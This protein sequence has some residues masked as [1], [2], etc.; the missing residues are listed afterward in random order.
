MPR[1][2]PRPP[3]NEVPPVTNL[4]ASGGFQ[5]TLEVNRDANGAI[6]GGKISAIGFVNFPGAATITGFHIH[7]GSS[8]TT[9]GI[10]FD[11]GIT[12]NNAVQVPM[13]VGLLTRDLNSDDAAATVARLTQLLTNPTNF[14]LNLHTTTHPNGALRA[15]LTKW[16]ESRANTVPM[17]ASQEVP[18]VTGVNAT[19]RAAILVNPTRN[20]TGQVN[21]GSITFNVAYEGFPP[22]TPIIGL[23]IHE[24]AAGTT[25]PIRFDTGLT[26]ANPHVSP[27]G[28]CFISITVPVTSADGIAALRRLIDNPTNFYVNLHT[29]TNPGGALRAQLTGLSNGAPAIALA[30]TY[31]LPTGS[32]NATISL[33]ATG[34]DLTSTVLINGQ[35]VT[36]VPDLTNGFINVTVPA[37]LLA[38][39]AVVQL[40]IRGGNGIF[41]PPLQLIISAPDLV[42]NVTLATVDA[43]SFNTTVTPG[44]IAAAFGTRLASQLTTLPANATVLPNAYANTT[45]NA[46]ETRTVRM[47]L[48][49][50]TVR[51]VEI[52]PPFLDMDE[53]VPVTQAHKTSVL[54]PVS[55][56]VMSVPPG[57]PLIGQ[58]ACD[59]T[60]PVYDGLVRFN[61][62]LFFKGV[63][64]VQ[65]KGYSGPVSVCSA[66]YTP[67]SGYKLDSQSTRYMAENR[68][69]E[70]WLAP[71]EQAHVVAPYYI[72][73]GTKS[74]TLVIQ[75]VD[76]HVTQQRAQNN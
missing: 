19:A 35:P 47:G 22:F 55:A 20:A 7:E 54:D 39:S 38:N 71:L 33:F 23:H 36:A 28:S 30:N 75:A 9:G 69:L 73:V 68:D 62:S 57:Q 41:S 1:I 76:F 12:T 49:A 18:P 70:V 66:R 53:R 24:G 34:I 40:Q 13:G 10:R 60:I 46:N 74:G 45:A 6:T 52:S 64:N 14:Y 27:T 21:G 16:V 61:V 5:L 67:I 44:S 2:V 26:T 11:S 72:K 50:G 56:L 8:T 25:G 29:P 43:A 32:S 4:S 48:N 51:A 15:Q 65:A 37:S 59:R 17:T 42:N 63:R 3:L 58:A 31:F